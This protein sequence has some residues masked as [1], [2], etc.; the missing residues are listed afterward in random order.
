MEMNSLTFYMTITSKLQKP[1]F[2]PIKLGKAFAFIYF[3]KKLLIFV[4]NIIL[5]LRH[6]FELIF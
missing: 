2:I 6:G 5:F 4:T 1:Y 3:A